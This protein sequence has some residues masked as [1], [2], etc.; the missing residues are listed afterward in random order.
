MSS[1]EIK[2]TEQQ[3]KAVTTN[4]LKT[5]VIAGPGSGKTKVLTER[6]CYLI[7]ELM[8]DKDNILALT[9]TSR[10]ANEMKKRVVDRLGSEYIGTEIMTFH[11][12]G[13]NILR[14]NSEL[15]GLRDGFDIATPFI[16]YNIIKELLKEN[17]ID[18]NK[19]NLILQN[20]SYIKNGIE[21]RDHDS[22]FIY[23]IYNKK[24]NEQKLLDLDDFII[25]TVELLENN[26]EIRQIY[27]RKYRYVL[28]DEFQDINIPQENMLKL[29][30]NEE[31]NIFLVGDDDQCIYEWRGSS[32]Q[33][34]N[35][36][37]SKQN[38][39][40]IRLED[41]FRSDSD[42][43]NLSEGFIKNNL[44]RIRKKVFS[45]KKDNDSF[46]KKIHYKKLNSAE[47]EGEEI[48]KQINELKNKNGYQNG[49]FAILVRSQK[50]IPSIIEALQKKDI[51][52][53]ENKTKDVNFINFIRVLMTVNNF[54][55]D[56]NIMLAI[57]FPNRVIGNVTY[58]NIKN[59]YLWS[60][61]TINGV[62]KNMYE[63]TDDFTNSNIF[64]ARYKL[65]KNLY[66]NK[67]QYAVSELI[68]QIILY[69]KS[70]DYMPS[71]EKN[72]NIKLSEQVLEIAKK[73]SVECG[74]SDTLQDF[75]DYLQFVLQ[76]DDET[77]I[78]SEKVN[79]MT[80][81]KAKGL[82][83]PVVFIPG[84][85]LG[86]FPNDYFVKTESDLEQERRLF[87][88]TMTRAINY[89]YITCYE[90]PLYIPPENSII[91]RSFITEILTLKGCL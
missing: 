33:I 71:E 40:V 3:Q 61:L 37:I 10:A 8:V 13:L 63:M 88:V 85:Q 58:R 62:L 44:R 74:E 31:T 28:I 12:L 1:I 79:I 82:E 75:I 54:N 83:F 52:Y 15:I 86:I 55:A 43:V 73:Y 20:I 27:H 53:S 56:K 57:N 29:L 84:V 64:K 39:E 80:C 59:K 18:N 50:Q 34:L 47:Q 76:S 7:K 90:N 22:L 23:D 14:D 25:K 78:D 65:L 26:T 6:I 68:E 24:L 81:H 45:R 32:P 77:E 41:N 42:I 4:S 51:P 91:K 36:F 2:L 17:F 48:A 46:V 19:I 38:V 89:L 72:I 21:I 69:Y 87:Y 67:S 30:T 9:F 60:T 35:D 16:K 5:A 70:E 11:K 66:E 49:D